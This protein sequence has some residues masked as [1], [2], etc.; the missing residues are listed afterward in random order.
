MFMN[1]AYYNVVCNIEFKV[2]QLSPYTPTY[3]F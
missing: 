1:Y 3:D 2:K